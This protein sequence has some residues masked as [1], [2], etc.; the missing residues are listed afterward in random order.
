MSSSEI[1]IASYAGQRTCVDPCEAT[2]GCVRIPC[3]VSFRTTVALHARAVL[4]LVLVVS[5]SQ[6]HLA[7]WEHE[8]IDAAYV[9]A[10]LPSTYLPIIS[11]GQHL[12]LRFVWLLI[13]APEATL[14]VSP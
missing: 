5:A 8:Q 12:L 9:G 6:L 11:S 7:P 3:L 2:P 4:F 1:T 14:L 13:P 10:L